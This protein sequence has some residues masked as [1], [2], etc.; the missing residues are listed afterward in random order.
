[1]TNRQQECLEWINDNEAEKGGRKKGQFR[2]SLYQF[3]VSA[4]G[5]NLRFMGVSKV[6]GNKP[7]NQKCWKLSFNL[8]SMKSIFKAEV[9]NLKF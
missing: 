1:M 5:M 2:I 9:Q 6:M 3:E 8:A 4:F 7:K